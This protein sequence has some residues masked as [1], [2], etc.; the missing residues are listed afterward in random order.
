MAA[1]K[2]ENIYE[3]LA[4]VRKAVEVVEKDSTGYGYKYVSD[5][6]LL[7]LISGTME[8]K[9]LTLI[10]RITPG[11]MKV[12]PWTYIKNKLHPKT[13]ELYDEV[14]NEIV[15]SAEMTYTWV[16]NDDPTETIEVPWILVGQQGDA[17]QSFGSALTYSYRYFLLKYFGVATVDDDPDNW[18]SRQKEAEAE[19]D[20][21]VTKE[22]I[23]E[24]DR[25]LRGYLESNPEKK[26]EVVEFIGKYAK[27]GKYKSITEPVM[28]GKLLKDF[29][30][31][32][33]SNKEE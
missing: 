11:T 32:Y 21:L 17:S 7:A 19:Q 28:A 1:D 31:T 26:D 18:R 3:K 15:V 4:E 5:R 16:N 14:N 20:R 10:P 8:A 22:T 25:I 24:F 33:V 27:G 9:H 23:E 29:K 13:K 30:D 12:E 2:K 6:E